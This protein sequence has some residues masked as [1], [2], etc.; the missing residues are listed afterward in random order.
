MR[1]TGSNATGCIR[2][3][4]QPAQVNYALQLRV[5]LGHRSSSFIAYHRNLRAVWREREE[6]LTIL[7]YWSLPPR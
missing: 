3:V 6:G 4:V 1:I 5:G 2:S 7:P